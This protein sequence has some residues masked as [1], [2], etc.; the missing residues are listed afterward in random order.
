MG[1]ERLEKREQ[2]GG[3]SVP[4]VSPSA[5]LGQGILEVEKI[6]TVMW[7][8]SN[9]PF[10]ASTTFYVKTRQPPSTFKTRRSLRYHYL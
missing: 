9:R 2:D 1:F 5:G 4:L 6:K 10:K 8:Q 7:S 3:L